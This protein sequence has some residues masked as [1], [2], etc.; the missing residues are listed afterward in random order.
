MSEA[1]SPTLLAPANPQAALNAVRACLPGHQLNGKTSLP[2]RQ[3]APTQRLLELK[4]GGSK[5]VRCLLT[6]CDP[7]LSFKKGQCLGT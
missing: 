6:L 3:V 2:A 1:D 4:T 5:N 7:D